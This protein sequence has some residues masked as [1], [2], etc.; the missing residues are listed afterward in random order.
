MPLM[1][2]TFYAVKPKLHSKRLFINLSPCRQTCASRCARRGIGNSCRFTDLTKRKKVNQRKVA[3][4]SLYVWCQVFLEYSVTSSMPSISNPFSLA[5][6]VIHQ[7]LAVLG[8]GQKATV[9]AELRKKTRQYG[10]K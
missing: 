4:R 1:H 2:S 7:E 5:K 10:L 3:V 9:L 6:L 8:T